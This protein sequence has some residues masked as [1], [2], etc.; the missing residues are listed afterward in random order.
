[1]FDPGDIGSLFAEEMPRVFQVPAQLTLAFGA[2]SGKPGETTIVPSIKLPS[3]PVQISVVFDW[4]LLLRLS[5][6]HA[7]ELFSFE[8]LA[9]ATVAPRPD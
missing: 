8:I 7:D 5:P 4:L 9:S 3:F 2:T 1:L 6:Q